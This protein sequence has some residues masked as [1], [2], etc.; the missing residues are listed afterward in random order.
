MSMIDIHPP[1]TEFPS[2]IRTPRTR[3]YVYVTMVRWKEQLIHNRFETIS[4]TITGKPL[5]PSAA[6]ASHS[7]L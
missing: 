7:V 2:Q 3:T 1:S 6:A 4:Y 5:G